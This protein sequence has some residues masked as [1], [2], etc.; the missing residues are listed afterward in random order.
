MAVRLYVDFNTM[1]MDPKERVY[2]NPHMQPVL[3]QELHP[4]M[5]VTLY[6]EEMAVEAVME[7]DVHDNTWLGQ[8]N[9]STRRDLPLPDNNDARSA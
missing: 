4:G 3:T 8:P 2:I 1:A 5:V 6:D 9:W 7:F